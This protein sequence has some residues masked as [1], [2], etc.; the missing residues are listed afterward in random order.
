METYDTIV[1]GA[2][3][4]GMAA[5]IYAARFNMK[6]LV[7]GKVVGGLLNESHNV[8]NYPGFKGIPGLDLM[9]QFKE[10]CDT[11]QIPFKEEWV[12]DAKIL[13]DDQPK[14]RLFALTTIDDNETP[15]TYHAKTVILTMGTKHKKLGAKGEERLSGKGV[16]Y[17]A[18][19][20]AAFYRNIPVAIVGGGDAAAQAGNLVAEF[21]SHVYMIVRKDQMR[22]EPINRTRL[23]KNPKVTLLYNTQVLEVL[24]DKEVEALHLSAPFNGSDMLKVSGMFVEIG[25]DIQSEL[26]AKL[27][28]ALNSHKEI[29]IDGESRTNIPGVY[30]AGDVG[31]RRYK[32]ALTGAAEGAIA[33]FGA[34]ELVKHLADMGADTNIEY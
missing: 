1:V 31:N 13:H 2:G 34:Y 22:A 17:C 23:E 10:H 29:I 11:L 19:C 15:H 14:K 32:Q 9:L 26:A 5:A 27:G 12:T 24:G 25:H 18:T 7:I 21:A 30:A 20:D 28:V 16:S 33:A 4:A 6:V 8:E 3:S